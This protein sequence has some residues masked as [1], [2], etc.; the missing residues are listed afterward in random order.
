MLKQVFSGIL[1]GLLVS[2]GG[3]VFLSVNDKVV[4]AVGFTIGLISVC[5]YGANLYTGRVG[6]LFEGKKGAVPELFLGL[7]GNLIGAVLAGLAM[8]SFKGEA[9]R[10][11]AGAVRRI[12]FRARDLLRHA[13]LHRRESVPGQEDDA[14]HPVRDPGV[15][16]ERLR[17]FHRGHVLFRGGRRVFPVRPSCSS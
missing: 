15:H 4:G 12:R 8:L 13:D 14:G 7:L 16:P 17:A 1:A 5:Y 10:R 11:E 6:Y 2:L 3:G 9:A